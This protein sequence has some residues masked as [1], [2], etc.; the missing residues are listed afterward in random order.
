MKHNGTPQL[1]E[2]DAQAIVQ[3]LLAWL[4]GYVPGWVPAKSGP[5]WAIIQIY[6]R[7]L[8][9]LAE[10]LNQAPDKNKLAFL[11][12]LGINLLPAQAARAPVVFQARPNLGDSSIAARTRVGAQVP[13]LAEP[14]MFETE[15]AIA[16][17]AA[18]LAEVVTLWPGRDSYADHSADAIAGRPFTLFAPLK[19]VPHEVYLAHDVH[20][21]LAG[22]STVELQFAL[23][24]PGSQSL[25][26]AWEYWDGQIWRAFKPFTQQDIEGESFD[27]TNGLTRSGVVRLVADCAEAAK[28]RVNG[29]ESYWIRG[30]STMPLVHLPGVVLPQVGHIAIGSVIERTGSAWVLSQKNVDGDVV[31]LSGSVR[32]ERGNVSFNPILEVTASEVPQVVVGDI[33]PPDPF[34]G[35]FFL[36]WPPLADGSLNPIKAQ[37]NTTYTILLVWRGTDEDITIFKTK[38]NVESHERQLEFSLTYGL[39]PDQAFADGTKLDTNKSFYPFGQ[40]PQPGSCFYF[41]SKEAFSK[42][43]AEVRLYPVDSLTP[44]ETGEGE[45]T[46]LMPTLVAEYWNGLQWRNLGL[47]SDTL[48]Q[49]ISGVGLALTLTIPNDIQPRKVNDVPGHWL[50]IRILSGTFGRRRTV[51]WPSANPDTPNTLVITETTPPALAAFSI[52]YRYRSPR[53]RPQ[54]CLTYNDFQWQDYSDDVKG[55]GNNFAPFAPVEDRTPTLY[56]GFDKPLP[57]ELVGLYLDIQEVE[58]LAEGPPLRWEYWDGNDWLGLSVEDETRGLALPGMLAALWPGV[59]APEQAMVLQA[60]STQVQLI[61]ARQ[62]AR[63]QH[64]DL[65]YV[66]QKDKGEL[67]TVA[68]VDGDVII[69]KAPLS[70]S[71]AQANI[72]PAALPRFGVPRTWMRARLQED[73]EPLR[74]YVNGIYLNAVWAS[75]TQ[76]IENEILGSSN[77]QVDQVYFTRNMPVLAGEIVEVRELDGPRAA[78]ELPLLIEE[79]QHQG[80]AEAD[81]RTVLDRRSG[82][83]DEVWVRWQQRPNLFF[84]APDERHYVIERSRGRLIFGDGVH[85]RVPPAGRDNI[86][87]QTYRSGGGVIGNV[88]RGTLNQLLSGGLAQSVTNP[89]AAE[90][91]ADVELIAAVRTRGPR[92]MRHRYQA[93]NL[94][95]YE[96]L[97]RQ[98]SPAVAVARALPTTHPSRRPARGWVKV[99]I[100]PQSQEPQPQPSFGLRRQVRDYL[101]ARMP[102]AIASQI[103]VEGPDYLPIGVEAVVVPTDP[104]AGGVVF[105]AV[106]AR[107][108]QFLHPLTGGPL[109]DGWPFGRDVYLSDVAAVLEHVAGVDYVATLNLLLDGTPRGERID[110]PGDR[111]VVV[112]PL[113]ITLQ[114]SER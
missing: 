22:K 27:A 91:G 32:D 9:A 18:Q 23:A 58:G 60:S 26:L 39:D 63:F 95:D 43:G 29:I 76:T 51:T 84:S 44:L 1:D 13:G 100:V 41:S 71:Y 6:A 2:R 74:Q 68:N 97:A 56:L 64:D 73:G 47:S 31:Q 112:G 90:G 57:P 98:A 4:P 72:G 80:L 78:V 11:D 107:L 49:L 5:G 46:L 15:R 114:G 66:S 24:T 106:T 104:A 85:G 38:V 110:V 30:R 45:Y 7:Y 50:R 42:P 105:A 83:V 70:R 21:A 36:E 69:L 96:D 17:P 87:I 53:D 37:P 77:A 103:A 54:A 16:L 75:Q 19:P 108:N 102:A 59:P 65:L 109:G 25:I 48:I 62:G 67:V 55:R 99:I 12:M 82:R 111:I 79:L 34:V 28:T 52:A 20:F 88:G 35:N 92:V 101:A 81:V 89:R 86:R 61:E 10:R 94:A 14:V 113:R 8:Q 33:F 40:Q 3:D 93:L